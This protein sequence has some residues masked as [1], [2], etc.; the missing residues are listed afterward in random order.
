MRLPA[1]ATRVNCHEHL[2]PSTFYAALQSLDPRTFFENKSANSEK[3]RQQ[4]RK[5]PLY[6]V[7]V[8]VCLN[9]T[10]EAIG[11]III[12]DNCVILR[13][14]PNCRNVV[15]T[16]NQSNA[17]IFQPIILFE[18][19]EKHLGRFLD[20]LVVDN[21]LSREPHVTYSFLGRS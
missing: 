20:Q 16:Y 18:P 11:L 8:R 2:V 7:Y 10:V 14:Q 6:E 15:W 17:G 19:K 5:Y 21:S 13:V 9:T 1:S 3:F 12:L 4:Y